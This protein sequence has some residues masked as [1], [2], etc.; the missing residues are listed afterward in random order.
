MKIKQISLLTLSFFAF[1]I[2][3]FAV[4]WQNAL[5]VSSDGWY[6]AYLPHWGDGAAHLS[7]M[8]SF[9]Y[10]DTFPQFHPLFFNHPFTY[11]F[12]TDLIGGLL[13]KLGLSL[14]HAYNLL[15]FCLSITTL[16]AIWKLLH[17]VLKSIPKTVLAANL[18]LL[19]GGLGWQ[20]LF[21]GQVN[22]D[23]QQGLPYL[24]TPLTQIPHT[25]IVWL[26]V[27]LGELLPQRAFL[28]GLP[29]GCLL[30]YWWISHFIYHQPLSRTKLVISGII[31]GLMPIVHPHTGMVLVGT[32][33]C[34]GL[35]NLRRHFIDLVYIAIPSLVVGLTSYFLFVASAISPGFFR[36]SPGWLAPNT[37]TSWLIFWWDNWG[38]FLPL[39]LI[40][41][42]VLPNAYKKLLLPFWLWFVLANLFL[43]QPYDW[44][45]AKILT[46]VHLLFTIPVTLL[47]SQV[48][49]SKKIFPRVIVSL[50]VVSLIISGGFDALRLL[51]TQTYRLPLLTTGE[52]ATADFI[53]RHTPKDAIILTSTSHRH[54]IP[55]ATGRQILCG[56]LG[57]MWTYGIN[58]DTRIKDIRDI[59]AGK[60]NADSLIHHYGIDYVVIGPEEKGE[61]AINQAFFTTRYSL[62]YQSP[63]I[64]IY[65]VN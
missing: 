58:A 16:F 1:W 12:V 3:Y 46:W 51:D 45:N 40:S 24:F 5:Q 8:S 64:S 37:Q 32:I 22:L 30:L 62:F 52:L 13:V 56:Y 50:I 21:T 47:L 49:T 60:P 57:W 44:D 36:F 33:A 31:L 59:Y 29:L 23:P 15:G 43:F 14:P 7:Y 28:L 10:R 9:A 26:N 4:V 25:D 65:Q 39:A 34:Y 48:I 11:S 27:L 19:S 18:F 17:L 6:S 2:I 42:L 53:R 55:I 38:L 54:Y 20:H 61:F 35:F 41:T 63:S